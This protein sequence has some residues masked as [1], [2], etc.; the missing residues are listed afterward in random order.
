VQG[1]HLDVLDRAI[2][3]RFAALGRRLAWDFGATLL[4]AYLVTANF[5]TS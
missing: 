2:D 4:T 5:I 3:E 1:G